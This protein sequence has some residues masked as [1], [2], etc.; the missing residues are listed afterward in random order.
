MWLSRGVK[1]VPTVTHT[2]TALRQGQ[3]K[4][5]LEL[6][7]SSLN[8]LG[9]WDT[10]VTV[11]CPCK[12][13]HYQ[14][15]KIWLN[16]HFLRK[17]KELGIKGKAELH[18]PDLIGREVGG[19]VGVHADLWRSLLQSRLRRQAQRC[20]DQKHASQTHLLDFTIIHK[21]SVYVEAPEWRRRNLNVSKTRCK[22]YYQNNPF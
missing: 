15:I 3:G 20:T 2:Y 13:T 21:V 5:N 18:T 8:I 7:S 14:S 11:L 10:E 1:R 6:F 12:R 16:W 4:F 9:F 22:R 19:G 17:L